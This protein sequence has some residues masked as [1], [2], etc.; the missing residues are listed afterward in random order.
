MGLRLK[1][2]LRYK[3][4]EKTIKTFAQF[5]NEQLKDPDFRKE[6]EYLQPDLWIVRKTADFINMLSLMEWIMLH[7]G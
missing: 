6:W 4:M 5:F 3:F 7:E 1:R 2:K